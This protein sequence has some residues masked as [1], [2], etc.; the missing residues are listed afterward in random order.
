MADSLTCSAVARA[1]LSSESRCAYRLNFHFWKQT[2]FEISKGFQGWMKLSVLC[3]CGCCAAAHA[4]AELRV[5]VLC[6]FFSC[7]VVCCVLVGAPEAVG[8]SANA[9]RSPAH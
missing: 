9:K 6:G 5:V 4:C 3:V 2:I 8:R 1:E 7:F